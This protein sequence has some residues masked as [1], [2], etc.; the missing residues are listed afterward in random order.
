MARPTMPIPSFEETDLST[1]YRRLMAALRGAGLFSVPDVQR[2]WKRRFKEELSRQTVHGWVR[3]RPSERDEDAMQLPLVT[4]FKVADLTGYAARWIVTGQGPVKHWLP[5]GQHRR[6]MELFEELDDDNRRKV[7]GY[8]EGK[9]QE[10]QP[11]K[12]PAPDK[13][14]SRSRE[15]A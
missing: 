1:V 8:A 4:L 13:P 3:E 15:K 7:I 11:A 5:D 10:Q 14:P 12:I 2:A 6:L 9:R